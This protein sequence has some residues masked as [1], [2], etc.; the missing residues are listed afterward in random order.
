[1]INWIKVEDQLPEKDKRVLIYCSKYDYV[2]TGYYIGNATKKEVDINDWTIE[3]PIMTIG[4]SI[5]ISH[6]ANFNTP[7]EL[8]I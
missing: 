7:E 8:L 5:S 1:M 2:S 6:W 4:A 3:T